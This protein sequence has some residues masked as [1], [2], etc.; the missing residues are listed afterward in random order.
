MVQALQ[1]PP[2]CS[3]T[4]CTNKE[5]ENRTTAL[6]IRFF[7]PSFSVAGSK[8]PVFIEEWGDINVRDFFKDINFT[9]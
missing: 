5:V 2:L 4:L 1:D 7:T 9:L 6:V 3:S 8:P